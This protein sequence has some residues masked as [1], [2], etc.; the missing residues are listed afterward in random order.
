MGNLRV[1]TAAS[2][3]WAAKRGALVIG[4]TVIINPPAR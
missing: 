4:I 1:V 2:V 3:S